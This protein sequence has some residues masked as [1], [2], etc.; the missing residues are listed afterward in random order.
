M[1]DKSL[2]TDSDDIK[3]CLETAV[4]VYS[5]HK[6]RFLVEEY[7][8][9]GT[10]LY[11]LPATWEKGRSENY[12]IEFPLDDSAE[13]ITV[14][15]RGM[16]EIYLV[17]PSTQ[18]L[19]FRATANGNFLPAD[20]QKFRLK[21]EVLH[22]L[23]PTSITVPDAHFLPIAKLGAREL[24]LMLATRLAQNASGLSQGDTAD[25][26]SKSSELQKLAETFYQ[27]FK[28]LLI[29]QG[30]DLPAAGSFGE[31]IETPLHRDYEPTFPRDGD[32]RL[33]M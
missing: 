13:Q 11:D 27:D 30:D 2:Q 14:L 19:R 29:P 4:A 20:G 12:E 21:Y 18:K 28:D 8:A 33:D 17:P 25:Y 24:C 3:D 9:D 15:D 22:Q 10:R 7:T 26:K 5:D 31:F 23:T 1:K 6:R 16:S 32:G